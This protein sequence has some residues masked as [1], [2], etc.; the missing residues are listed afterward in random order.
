[1]PEV[2]P[3][4]S[5]VS[6]ILET[7]GYVNQSF[8]LDQLTPVLKGSVGGFVFLIGVAVAIF[9]TAIRGRYVFASWL[10]IGPPLFFSMLVRGEIE[11]AKWQFATEA[12]RQAHVDE[13]VQHMVEAWG[14]EKKPMV[15]SKFFARYNELVSVTIQEMLKIINS[16]RKDMDKMFIYKGQVFGQLYASN[17]DETSLS[18]F[19][20]DALFGE[21][22]EFITAAGVVEDDRMTSAQKAVAS[23]ILEN[24]ESR[25]T[26]VLTQNAANYLTTQFFGTA[27]P[28]IDEW[29]EAYY[30]IWSSDYTCAEIWDYAYQGL[31][32]YSERVAKGIE[33][34]AQAND[35]DTQ[36]FLQE[37][38]SAATGVSSGD[39]AQAI[40]DLKRVIAKYILRNEYFRRSNSNMISRRA[41]G[42]RQAPHIEMKLEKEMLQTESARIAANEWME[43]TRLLV[44][45]SNL[46]YYQGLGLYFLATVFPF[47]ALLLLIPGK[48]PGFI[49]WFVL[50]LW[51][52]SWDIG[53]A[54]VM[55]LDDV[56]F[57]LFTVHQMP[58][59]GE[60]FLPQDFNLAMFALRIADPTFQMG[61]YYTVLA[62]GV[63]AI[64]IITSQILLGSLTGGAGLVSA[65]ITQMGDY[66]GRGAMTAF[67]QTPATQ[68][69]QQMYDNKMS[70]ALA[71]RDARSGRIPLGRKERAGFAAA[72]QGS[73]ARDNTMRRFLSLSPSTTPDSQYPGDYPRRANSTLRIGPHGG[74]HEIIESSHHALERSMVLAKASGITGAMRNP[75]TFGIE[76]VTKNTLG[77]LRGMLTRKSVRTLL[78]TVG[79]AVG[80][81]I[82]SFLNT[83]IAMEEAELDTGMAWA[84]YDTY[85]SDETMELV[86]RAKIW[87]MLEV[88]WTQAADGNETGYLNESNYDFKRFKHWS[89]M[90]GSYARGAE[91]ALRNFGGFLGAERGLDA[92]N[93]MRSNYDDAGLPPELFD[94][95]SRFGE[96]AGVLKKGPGSDAAGAFDRQLKDALK[97]EGLAD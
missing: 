60:A 14:G 45:A 17:L 96:A 78:G 59:P 67:G 95:I 75:E 71:E 22:G 38:L 28:T 19:I 44:A 81:P 13:E 31:L 64:P 16:G 76:R 68:L 47:F 11:N 12:R 23:G 20:H 88:P 2:V 35:I 82:D 30:Y 1:M 56:L 63:L 18:G 6:A 9:A 48:H 50:W 69:K 34:T 57:S 86:R 8:L 93:T 92:L 24:F 62:T 80:Q 85:Y 79:E 84:V 7:G 58:K 29:D 70:R 54:V 32:Q 51:L 61:T 37:I 42:I 4:A 33:G 27:Q 72:A 94:N 87:G 89:D 74:R 52:K 90:W 3:A 91:G 36:V 66:L 41:E 53:F 77:T 55:L 26:A 97:K 5:M 46:P 40:N 15:V 25:R 39:N 43:K 10:L 83:S 65:G 21:C 73:A 49:L